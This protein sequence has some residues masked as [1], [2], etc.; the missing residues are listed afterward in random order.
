VRRTTG[1][2]PPE[3]AE[4]PTLPHELEYL[5]D[6]FREVASTHE[7]TWTELVSYQTAARRILLGWESETIM[8]LDRLLHR[9]RE[10]LSKEQAELLRSANNG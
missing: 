1:E 5:W 3:L 9:I 2:A 4:A 8:S 7:L 10:Q 6:I